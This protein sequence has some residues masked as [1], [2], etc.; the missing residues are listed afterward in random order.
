MADGAAEGL[1][2]LIDYEEIEDSDHEHEPP[3]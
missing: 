3:R 2:I 1:E